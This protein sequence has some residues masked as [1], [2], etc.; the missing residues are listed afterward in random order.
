MTDE[1]SLEVLFEL[2]ADEHVRW[3]LEQLQT[4]PQSPAELADSSSASLSTICRRL[5][6]LEA[7]E[8]VEG[9]TRLRDD[10]NHDTVYAASLSGVAVTLDD[11]GLSVTVDRR[12]DPI[13]R[14][15]R[16]W[17]EF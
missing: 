5:D 10:G 2:L 3:I 15:H 4:A 8:L 11:E 9:Q 1:P 14:L 17:G 13:D 12:E 16:L 6:D 7:A